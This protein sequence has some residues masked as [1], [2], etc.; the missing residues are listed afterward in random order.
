MGQEIEI[1]LHIDDAAQME[2]VRGFQ[3]LAELA[4]DREVL[5]RMETVY[6]DTPKDDFAERKW[7][8]RRRQENET[9][10]ICLKT[11]AVPGFGIG[12]RGEWETTETDLD[13]AIAALVFSGAPA[14][15][16]KLA[17][18]GLKEICGAHFVRR[19]TLLRLS[20]GSTCELA[21]DAG[22]LTGGGQSCR[23]YEIELELKSGEQTQMQALAQRLKDSFG[24]REEKRSK[25]VRA[26]NLCDAQKGV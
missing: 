15:L 8:F 9:G 7:T 10:V 21:C 14:E 2:T 18:G 22:E 24:L 5:Y 20:D 25:F 23:F 26:R 19:A 12:V 16:A 17:S 4:A 3:E 13:K 6:Y 11:P 1:K